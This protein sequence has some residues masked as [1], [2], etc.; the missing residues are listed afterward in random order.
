MNIDK[1][2]NPELVNR[3]NRL[4]HGFST[5]QNR[6]HNSPMDLHPETPFLLVNQFDNQN[7]LTSLT[8]NQNVHRSRSCHWELK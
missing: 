6:E 2:R 3:N 8:I 5:R 7:N 4:T 1:G